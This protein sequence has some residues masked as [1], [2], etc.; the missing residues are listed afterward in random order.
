MFLCSSYIEF[1][2][3]Y[4]NSFQHCTIKAFHHFTKWQQ[5]QLSSPSQKWWRK[6]HQS[7][8]A[9]VIV[10]GDDVCP[11]PAQEPR[12][13]REAGET[14]L[15]LQSVELC[16]CHKGPFS[17]AGPSSWYTECKFEFKQLYNFHPHISNSLNTKTM[18]DTFICYSKHDIQFSLLLSHQVVIHSV[19]VVSLNISVSNCY[20]DSLSAGFFFNYFCSVKLLY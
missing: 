10:T 11:M 6:Y 5:P 4:Y 1:L 13:S 16:G 2:I 20:I 9:F 15:D 3:T 8:F 19:Q 17:Q 12:H 7:W 18:H 14:Q